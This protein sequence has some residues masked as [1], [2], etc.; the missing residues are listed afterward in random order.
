LQ[1]RQDEEGA[2]HVALRERSAPVMAGMISRP[3][4]RRPSAGLST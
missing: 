2:D 1:Q 4:A 3:T